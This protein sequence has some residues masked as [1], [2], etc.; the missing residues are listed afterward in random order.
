MPITKRPRGPA[1]ASMLTS[2]FHALTD[3]KLVRPSLSLRMKPWALAPASPLSRFEVG[4]DEGSKY[5]LPLPMPLPTTSSVALAAA[6]VA[7]SFDVADIHCGD[8]HGFWVAGL[9]G[10]AVSY[11]APTVALPSMS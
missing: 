9:M 2:F 10:V 5:W 11:P 7:P 8:V 3:R 1:L 6:T 4:P